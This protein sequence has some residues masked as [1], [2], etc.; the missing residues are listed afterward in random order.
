[1]VRSLILLLLLVGVF[2][3]GILIG[4]DREESIYANHISPEANVVM[5]I[6]H[7]EY[8]EV[9]EEEQFL[10]EEQGLNTEDPEQATQK[11]AA[12]LEAGVKGFYEVI[13]EILFQIASLF[14]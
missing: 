6:E 1:M 5:P 9:H 10:I 11:V 4:I 7:I 14:V 12:F 2:L 13:V 8:W 3:S